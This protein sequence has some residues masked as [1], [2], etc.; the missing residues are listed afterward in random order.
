MSSEWK[1]QQLKFVEASRRWM[2]SDPDAKL[3]SGANGTNGELRC[4]H[5]WNMDGLKA[6]RVRVKAA[7]FCL[8]A[9]GSPF[10]GS[11]TVRGHLC[12]NR[13][14]M[15]LTRDELCD[16][17][18][19]EAIPWKS[20]ETT[21][22]DFRIS[23]NKL[24]DDRSIDKLYSTY[25]CSVI[26]LRCCPSSELHIKLYSSIYIVIL[27]WPQPRVCSNCQRYIPS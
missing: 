7:L 16:E 1:K 17:L 13:P 15:L 24:L 26:V 18:T 4:S 21:V 19:H 22:G 12:S 10:L 5:G 25:L 11:S 6:I 23:R 2:T 8:N 3:A 14:Y 20:G 27:P 9:K